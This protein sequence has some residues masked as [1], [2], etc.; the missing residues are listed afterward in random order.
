MQAELPLKRT[1]KLVDKLWD[2]LKKTVTWQVT[3]TVT[4]GIWGGVEK[5]YR[6][7]QD[8]NQSLTDI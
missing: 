4:H 1:N 5:A 8:L 6:Y 2:S 3:S 7:A